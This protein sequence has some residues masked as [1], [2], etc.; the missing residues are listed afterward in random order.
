MMKKLAAC[1]LGPALICGVSHAENFVLSVDSGQALGNS[2][3]WSVALGALDGD[4]DFAADDVPAGMTQFGTQEASR[5]EE[6]RR[7][8]G[9]DHPDTLTA[10]N[11]MGLT[12]HNQGKYEEALSYT[13][14]ALEAR[15]RV[16]GN[17]HPD[18][19]EILN[20]LLELYSE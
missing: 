13:T 11:K 19:R 3:S 9:N 8:L 12:L 5:L 1:V 6:R 14:E 15:R 7:V 20:A 16:L 17:D 10:I 4:G 18:T 2:E